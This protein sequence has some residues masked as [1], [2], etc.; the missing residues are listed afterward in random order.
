MYVSSL[1]L[2]NYHKHN[3]LISYFLQC[4]SAQTT[5]VTDDAMYESGFVWS[6]RCYSAAGS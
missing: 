5:S 3:F 2:S 1:S 6:W 4:K